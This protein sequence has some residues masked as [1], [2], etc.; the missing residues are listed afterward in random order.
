LNVNIDGI[1]NIKR[2]GISKNNIKNI[3]R[4]DNDRGYNNSINKNI[5]SNDNDR[6]Y[7]T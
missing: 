5:N 7:Y 4:D 2:D 3:K 1:N 6:G